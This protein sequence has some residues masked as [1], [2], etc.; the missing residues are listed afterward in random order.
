MDFLTPEPLLL[1]P[2]AFLTGLIDS[3]VG[4][5]GLIQVPGIFSILPNI[6]PQH[7]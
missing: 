4:G 7:Y 5:G 2:L 6:S 3:A 1:I